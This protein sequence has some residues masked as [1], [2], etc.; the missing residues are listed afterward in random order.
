MSSH[1]FPLRLILML[2]SCLRVGFLSDHFPT[3]ILYIFCSYRSEKRVRNKRILSSEKQIEESNWKVVSK[4]AYEGIKNV[5]NGVN[6]RI[7]KR[8]NSV[9][10][11]KVPYFMFC[12]RK[13]RQ[14]IDFHCPSWTRA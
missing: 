12:G 1:F 10:R 6:V 9:I 2:S 7:Q 8:V 13:L 3:K 14:V 11:F 5:Q 4:A